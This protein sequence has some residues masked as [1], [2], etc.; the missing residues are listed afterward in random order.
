MKSD[1]FSQKNSSDR[2][3]FTRW[4][5]G[6]PQQ[7]AASSQGAQK[8]NQQCTAPSQSAQKTMLS[9][10]RLCPAKIGGCWWWHWGPRTSFLWGKST[11]S[12][13]GILSSLSQKSRHRMIEGVMVTVELK[14]HTAQWTFV[15]PGAQNFKMLEA[16]N[17]IYSAWCTE[18]CVSA[19]GTFGLMHHHDW[20]WIPQVRLF[21][22][23]IFYCTTPPLQISIGV[24]LF[25]T[26]YS[27][28]LI[29][30][31]HILILK[32]FKHK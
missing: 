21:I 27:L 5:T 4:L 14:Q 9:A 30:F 28:V 6:Q 2:T 18:L 26:F 32:N 24:L 23:A 11:L 1:F 13:W 17:F 29:I 16:S 22:S 7:C 19:R 12:E 3:T 15:V 20:H 25:F 10:Q 8:A 31:L